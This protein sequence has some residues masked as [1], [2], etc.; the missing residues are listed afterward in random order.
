MSHDLDK[1]F[2]ELRRAVDRQASPPPVRELLGRARADTHDLATAVSD[3]PARRTRTIA[4]TGGRAHDER[5]E[6]TSTSS[7]RRRGA[8]VLGGLAAAA[9][10]VGPAVA[11][12][13]PMSPDLGDA[14]PATSGPTVGVPSAPPPGSA[15]SGPGPVPSPGATPTAPEATEQPPPP[16]A[17]PTGGRTVQVTISVLSRATGAAGC[18]RLVDVTRSVP[19]DDPV[20]GAVLATLAGVTADERA[21]GLWSV[22]GEGGRPTPAEVR[23]DHRRTS[24]RLDLRTLRDVDGASSVR[25]RGEEI[26]EPVNRAIRRFGASWTT[27]FLVGGSVEAQRAYVDRGGPAVP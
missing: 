3:D 1:A 20:R 22:W 10:L 23:V 18:S 4:G 13:F 6:V 14:A 21:R 16:S 26:R 2:D 19:A 27:T 8:F 17:S 12:V 15:G 25:C 9:A 11:I 5:A 24:V 7:G